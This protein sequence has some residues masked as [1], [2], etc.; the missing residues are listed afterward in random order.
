MKRLLAYLLIIA[1][2]LAFTA[3]SDAEPDGGEPVNGTNESTT[4]DNSQTHGLTPPCVD[5]GNNLCEGE[6]VAVFS[7]VS[8][9]IE[10]HEDWN[11]NVFSDAYILTTDDET[12]TT[13][14]FFEMPLDESDEINFQEMTDEKLRELMDALGYE[15]SDIVSVVHTA[16]GGFPGLR[17]DVKVDS[18]ESTGDAVMYVF[19]AGESA[20]MFIFT[21]DESRFGE[22]EEMASS[23]AIIQN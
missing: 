1:M 2:I 3:C 9:S 17:L 19:F 5:C 13:A 20:Y 12:N 8:F 6:C 10:V 18:E 22:F 7:A 4:V 15:N 21:G 16:V 11:S 14:S 23:F